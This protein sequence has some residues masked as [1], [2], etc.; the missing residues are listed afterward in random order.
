MPWKRYQALSVIFRAL[1]EDIVAQ[2]DIFKTAKE[3]WK[4]LK[5]RH[6]GAACIVKAR[7]QA[8]QR[9]F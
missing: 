7:I 2:L 9:E 5:T 3:T 4:L 6:Q 8:L 1:F